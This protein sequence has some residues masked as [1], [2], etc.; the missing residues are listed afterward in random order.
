MKKTDLA[1]L[2][3]MTG[4]DN[5][6]IKEMIGIFIDQVSEIGFEMEKVNRKHNHEVM[7]KLAHK[8]KSSVAIMGMKKLSEKLKELEQL[9]SEGN[10]KTDYSSYIKYF[11][12]ECTRAI[13]ELNEYRENLSS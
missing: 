12:E 2:E 9:I 7:L 3:S 10:H 4:N 6:L 8:A 1:Y 11:N 5:R 13:E